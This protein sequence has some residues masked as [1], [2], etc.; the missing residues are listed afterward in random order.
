MDCP[1][2]MDLKRAY[3]AGLSEYIGARSSVCF[4]A[5]TRL[6]ARKNVEMERARYDL[7]EHQSVCDSALRAPSH[8]PEREQPV[9]LRPM[10][11]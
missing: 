4:R 10:A 1:I 2:C 3:E 5:C 7:E 6:A 8:L 11:A 9:N